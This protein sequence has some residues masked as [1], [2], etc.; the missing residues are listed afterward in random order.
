MLRRDC[1]SVHRISLLHCLA[2]SS[3]SLP[4]TVILFLRTFAEATENRCNA[5][6]RK[7]ESTL[8]SF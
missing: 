7:R 3:K 4:G 5:I 1:A 6:F 2:P 8:R